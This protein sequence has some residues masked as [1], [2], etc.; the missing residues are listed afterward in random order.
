MERASVRQQV[1]RAARQLSPRAAATQP[2]SGPSSESRSGRRPRCYSTSRKPIYDFGAADREPGSLS[3]Q[4]RTG[5]NSAG[6][7][8]SSMAA[9]AQQHLPYPGCRPQR[10]I[11]VCMCIYIYICIMYREREREIDTWIDRNPRDSPPPTSG[12]DVSPFESDSQTGSLETAPVHE[13]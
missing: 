6:M 10:E 7:S 8:T 11:Q 4:E 3:L 12:R 5:R 9:G 2:V 13:G 1:G